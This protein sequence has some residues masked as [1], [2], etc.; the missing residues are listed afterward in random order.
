MRKRGLA[1]VLARPSQPVRYCLVNV[2]PPFPVQSQQVPVHVQ[3]SPQPVHHVQSLPGPVTHWS[4]AALSCPVQ[5]PEP[6][7]QFPSIT[8]SSHQ[9]SQLQN[10]R[11]T[12]ANV[13]TPASFYPSTHPLPLL[14]IFRV[15]TR[16]L[17]IAN[18]PSFHQ[19]IPAVFKT[20]H[21][22]TW[23]PPPSPVPPLSSSHPS[24][25]SPSTDSQ[26]PPSPKTGRP[27]RDDAVHALISSRLNASTSSRALSR[28][29][30]RETPP[31]AGSLIQ[32]MK[33]ARRIRCR[34]PY[35]SSIA[36]PALPPSICL[37][38]RLSY[39]VLP[40]SPF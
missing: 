20:S 22:G 16:D 21:Q 8:F 3:S 11:T 2:G 6:L 37:L 25:Q 17:S 34:S 32:V 10:S 36:M 15:S 30:R 38:R 29:V 13:N 31:G 4:V 35:P 28:S 23:S 26:Q 7:P 18:Y 1:S 27:L 5:C 14:R 12:L 39:R 33:S 40:D 24:P 9:L 19:N